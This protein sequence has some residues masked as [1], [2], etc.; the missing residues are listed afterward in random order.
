VYR[1]G[2]YRGAYRLFERT[3]HSERSTGS[4]GIARAGSGA[5]G[6][7]TDPDPDTDSNTTT[8]DTTTSD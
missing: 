1:D 5:S 6:A 4:C 3:R 2:I 7:D 8:S